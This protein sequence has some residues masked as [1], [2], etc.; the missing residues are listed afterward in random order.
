MNN[1]DQ[2]IFAVLLE[3][4]RIEEHAVF[5][6][7][8]WPFPREFFGFAK[9]ER[10]DLVIEIGQTF[11]RVAGRSHVIQLRRLR[12]R[13]AGEGDL[14]LAADKG[15]DPEEPRWTDITKR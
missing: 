1:Q 9:C 2:R 10:G 3:I 8:V 14:A 5:L 12:W 11:R 13:T 15:I 6:E 7:A 4:G